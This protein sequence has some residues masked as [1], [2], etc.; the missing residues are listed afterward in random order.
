MELLLS[1]VR[2]HQPKTK[3]DKKN[4]KKYN[5]SWTLETW[6]VGNTGV[7]WIVTIRTDNIFTIIL[8]LTILTLNLTH[9]TLSF[10]CDSGTIDEVG[11]VRPALTSLYY[12][13]DHYKNE[14]ICNLIFLRH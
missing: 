2:N 6:I 10:I 9:R 4:P 12:D 5:N 11:Q 14:N 13:F 7:S 8:L 1:I 3:D